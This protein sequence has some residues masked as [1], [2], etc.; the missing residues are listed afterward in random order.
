MEQLPPEQPEFIPAYFR[1]RQ[2]ILQT[3]DPLNRLELME[4]AIVEGDRTMAIYALETLRDLADEHPDVPDRLNPDKFVHT[5]LLTEALAQ[6]SMVET[7]EQVI[8]Y[9]RPLDLHL[10]LQAMDAM[11]WRGHTGPDGSYLTLAPELIGWADVPE[12]AKLQY[13]AHLAAY[14]HDLLDTNSDAR[15]LF[16]D[17]LSPEAPQYQVDRNML[18][19]CR[20]YARTGQFERAAACVDTIRNPYWN[21]EA[22]LL[23]AHSAQQAGQEDLAR[24]WLARGSNLR[25][26]AACD[27]SCGRPSCSPRADIQALNARAAVVHAMRGE[28]AR[29]IDMI[30]PTDV[31]IT[32]ERREVYLIHYEQTGTMVSRE[33]A[34]RAISA[35]TDPAAVSQVER[36]FRADMH[37]G[38]L[39]PSLEAGNESIPM[40][41]W[42]I[43]EVYGRPSVHEE[44]LQSPEG[45]LERV[46]L[47]ELFNVP[48][49]EYL[50]Q[51]AAA[52]ADLRDRLLAEMVKNTAPVAPHTAYALL[53]LIEAQAERA[54]AVIAVGRQQGY[55]GFFKQEPQAETGTDAGH[56]ESETKGG[57]LGATS[58]MVLQALRRLLDTLRHRPPE[59]K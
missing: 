5:I 52:R 9:A 13:A 26:V 47:E 36:I 40:I 15:G 53:Q 17:C 18:Q 3:V 33:I 2:Q 6:S 49:S 55:E 59:D 20:A 39:M 57:V 28:Y 51:N 37:W 25:A 8:E 31:F 14:G 41:C 42:E 50:A 29:A 32:P 43:N 46:I 30:D 7:A 58:D 1:T 48:I 10:A 38:N 19:I 4:A 27:P 56:T 24:T 54:R 22:A 16:D 23:L 35:I 34:L 44:R 21:R 11:L 12:R 45:E